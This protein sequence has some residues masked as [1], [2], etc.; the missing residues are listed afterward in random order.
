V[1][2]VV[3]DSVPRGAIQAGDLFVMKLCYAVLL[4]AQLQDKSLVLISACF[5][6]AACPSLDAIH[7]VYNYLIVFNIFTIDSALSRLFRRLRQ[8]L[9]F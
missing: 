2:G 3:G 6:G 1:S 7:F 9:L 5:A 4:Q 8:C